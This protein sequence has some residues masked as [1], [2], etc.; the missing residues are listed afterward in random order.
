MA[1]F[2]PDGGKSFDIINFDKD[3]ILNETPCVDWR[4]A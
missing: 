3:F 1:E 4:V 2:I